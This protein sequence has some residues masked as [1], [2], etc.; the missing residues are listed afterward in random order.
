MVGLQNVAELGSGV[1]CGA[2]AGR[3]AGR[4][5]ASLLALLLAGSAITI[6]SPVAAITLDLM[7]ADTTLNGIPGSGTITNTSGG[8]ATL[9]SSVAAG[10]FTFNGVISDTAGNLL[11]F[12]KTGAG[13]QRL[14]GSNTYQGGTEIV[15]GE[16]G[17]GAGNSLGTGNVEFTGAGT[18]HAITA[19][20]TI[21]N[22]IVLTASGTIIGNATIVT[23][24]ISGAGSLT[25][26][27]TVEIDN[28][29][30]SYTGGTL[31]G[32]GELLL[33]A[34]NVLGTGAV[35]VSA[36]SRLNALT[37][38]SL[39]NAVVLNADLRVDRLGSVL[40]LNGVVSGGAGNTLTV[41]NG[42][43]LDLTGANT[44]VGSTYV[45]S[46]TTDTSVLGIGNN[47]AA[48]GA[49]AI[50]AT[51]VDPAHPAVVRALGGYTLAAGN[52]FRVNGALSVDTNGNAFGINGQI[53]DFNAGTP[54]SLTATGGG[55]LTLG[56]A[57]NGYTLG[58]TVTGF[59]QLVVTSDGQ[60]G[61]GNAGIALSQGYLDIAGTGFGAT[62]RV[63]H[64]DRLRRR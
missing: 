54:G 19:G 42:A 38:A 37:T 10:T 49:G 63:N 40:T 7:G 31:L 30:N 34:S 24:V 5:R 41:R 35:T 6:S 33:G 56:A 16:L 4:S 3:R 57:S 20:L 51:S 17:F 60:L 11:K 64:T 29:G 36:N 52:A 61:N 22:N 9:T 59:T 62:T 44:Y 45:T 28:T 50:I 46:T 12:R 18:L 39:D 53:N 1:I 26:L 25:K 14:G 47:L 48:G 15:A 27:G 13:T 32:N 8:N 55:L 23:G 2:R 58:T 43:E 21:A